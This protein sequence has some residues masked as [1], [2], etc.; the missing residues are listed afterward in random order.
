MQETQNKASELFENEK[1]GPNYYGS[2]CTMNESS[3]ALENERLRKL[4]SYHVIDSSTDEIFQH[5][6]ALASHTFDVPISCVSLVDKDCVWLKS[7]SSGITPKTERIPGLCVTAIEQSEVHFLKDASQDDRSKANP[8]VVDGGI[9]FYAGK[10]LTTPDGYNIGAICVMGMEP[11]DISESEIK[12]LDLLSRLTMNEI[13]RHRNA[14]ELALAQ[15]SLQTSEEHYIALAEFS[16]VG[17]FRYSA[18]G[19]CVYANQR[20]MQITGM[21]FEALKGYG[22]VK[23]I[24]PEDREQVAE[25]FRK[26]IETGELFESEN[27][28]ISP[29]GEVTLVL[30]LVTPEKNCDGNI[31]GFVG[32]LTDMTEQ[33]ELEKRVQEA[34]K[35]ESLA[36]LAGG[37]AHDFNNLLLGVMGNASLLQKKISDQYQDQ[38]NL[39]NIIKAAQRASDLCSQMLAYAGKGRFKNEVFDLFHLL[40]ETTDLLRVNM[41]PT[42]EVIIKGCENMPKLQGDITQIQ[43]VFLNLITNAAE[44]IGDAPG[45]V[46]LSCGCTPDRPRALQYNFLD[47][48]AN[49]KN[50]VT[51]KLKDS[52]SGIAPDQLSKIFDPFYTTKGTGHGLGMAA[53][54]GI[55]KAHKGGIKIQ[56]QLGLG[57][58]IDLYFPASSEEQQ[59]FEPVDQIIHRRMAGTIL[60]ADDDD[61]AREILVETLQDSGFQIL[62]AVDGEEAVELFDRHCEEISLVVLDMIMP[63]LN[64]KD[65]YQR[66]REVKSE[67]PVLFTSGYHEQDLSLFSGQVGK[68]PVDFLRKPFLPEDLTFAVSKLLEFRH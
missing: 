20:A 47:D 33:R 21:S 17:I 52:G 3:V 65:A 51:I 31:I 66:L 64:G 41:P 68:G 40:Q 29:D 62:S 5:I 50:F 7:D 60:I 42:C 56:S 26:S 44:S 55:V 25:Y 30:A 16:P 23:A 15:K 27:R 37:I 39:N 54:L 6:T 67:M 43:Q 19:K 63:K 61:V 38:K 58:E 53:I 36:L 14:T 57:T 45:T 10:S 49:T 9:R 48:S 13:E 18:E 11:R 4:Y 8:S 24:H 32:T 28:M 22:F 1:P 35:F 59:T 34:Q 46:Q 12:H 2:L